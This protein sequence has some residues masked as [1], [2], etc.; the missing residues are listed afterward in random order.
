MKEKL[1]TALNQISDRHIED[2]AKKRTP[3]R[4]FWF[5]AAAAVLAAVVLISAL[6]GPMTIRAEALAEAGA[7]RATPRPNR[8]DYKEWEDWD[9]AYEAY[10]AEDDHRRELKRAALD[11]LKGFFTEG[12]ARFLSGAD[13][14]RLWSPV[15]AAIGLGALTELTGGSS[16]KQLL[17]ALGAKDMDSLRAQVSALWESAYTDGQNGREASRLATSLWLEKGLNCSRETLEALS[18]HHYA[19][20]YRGDLGSGKINSAIGAWLNNNTGGLLKENAGNIQLPEETVLALYSTLFFQSKW[21]SEFNAANNKDGAFHAPGGDVTVTYMT[22]KLAMMYYYWGD[23]FSAVSLSLKN[24]SQMWFI[25][26]DEGCSIDTVLESGQY[27][28][29]LMPGQWENSKYMKVNLSVPKFDVT[30]TQNLKDGLMEMGITDVFSDTQADF[31]GITSQVPVYLTAANQAVRVQVDEEGVKAA[32][33]IEF[34]G[35]MSPAPPD[36]IIDFVLDRPFL[37]FVT[38]DN[39]PLF[40][41]AVNQPQ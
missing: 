14:N 3:R 41:G 12:S 36:E 34:P 13:G 37:F 19:S 1:N 35:A 26:P 8:D 5:S 27:L 10:K 23:T 40:A 21:V 39:V 6:T 2:A 15:N 33:Y 25:L 28:D 32:A 31:S 20:V 24:G 18:Y 22:K 4:T 30:G 11:S 29:L 38:K 9:A 17:D 7:S 16:R